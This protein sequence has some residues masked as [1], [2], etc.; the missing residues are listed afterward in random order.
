MKITNETLNDIASADGL[1]LKEFKE[2]LEKEG[3]SFKEF[4]ESIK[5]E[6]VKR[7]VQSGLV[8][9]KIVISEQEIKNYIDYKK[10]FYG[11]G[12]PI[13]LIKH[14]FNFRIINLNIGLKIKWTYHCF[15]TSK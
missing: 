3:E 15:L 5:N 11:W 6:Y 14:I 7:R 10:L 12:N 2:K 13:H 4:R 8:R 9:P 1:T